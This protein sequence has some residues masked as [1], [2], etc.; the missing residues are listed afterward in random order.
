M[1]VHLFCT[2]DSTEAPFTVNASGE[3]F[4]HTVKVGLTKKNVWPVI[5]QAIDTGL[6]AII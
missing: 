4:V 3:L 1:P 5:V 2:V 6:S